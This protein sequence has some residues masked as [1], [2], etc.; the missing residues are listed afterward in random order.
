MLPAGT[1][2]SSMAACLSWTLASHSGSLSAEFDQSGPWVFAA[3]RPSLEHGPCLCVVARQLDALP[4]IT[5]LVGL[6]LRVNGPLGWDPSTPHA[7]RN[8]TS[9]FAAC[10]DSWASSLPHVGSKLMLQSG[11]V[12]TSHTPAWAGLCPRIAARSTQLGASFSQR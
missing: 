10:A 8:V 6:Q 5:M 11:L 1:R 2:G 12:E 4:H 9:R 3:W 7:L